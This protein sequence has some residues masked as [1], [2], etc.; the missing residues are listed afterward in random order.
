[1]QVVH[2][3]HV[4]DLLGRR[5]HDEGAAEQHDDRVEIEHALDDA[6]P[7]D[8]EPGRLEHLDDIYQQEQEPDAQDHRERDAEAPHEGLL[9]RRRALRLER[10]VQQVVE[11]QHGLQQRQHGQREEIVDREEIHGGLHTALLVANSMSIDDRSA[12]LDYVKHMSRLLHFL[13]TE[14]RNSVTVIGSVSHAT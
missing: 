10:D 11:A 12:R 6:G 1:M 2:L 13:F 7:L 3:H 5:V 9:V 8:L 14:P 4:P